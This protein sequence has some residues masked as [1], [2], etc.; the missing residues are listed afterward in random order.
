MTIEMDGGR[1]AHR[2]VGPCWK[3]PGDDQPNGP[4]GSTDA[5]PVS[6]PSKFFTNSQG[7][8]ACGRAIHAAMAGGKACAFPFDDVVHQEALVAQSSPTKMTIT[9]QLLS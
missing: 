9:V 4:L 3:S 8:N 1:G 6:D 2:P 7:V 5:E